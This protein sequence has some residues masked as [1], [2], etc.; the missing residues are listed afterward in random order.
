MQGTVYLSIAMFCRVRGWCK[1]QYIG[2]QCNARGVVCNACNVQYMGVQCALNMGV[3][4][5]VQRG[6]QR[7]NKHE[8][9]NLTPPPHSG[10]F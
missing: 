10:E 8:S 4:F 1:M 2:V 3:V 7:M 6:K 9:T 5:G